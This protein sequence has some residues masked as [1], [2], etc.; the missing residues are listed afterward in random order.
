[1]RRIDASTAERTQAEIV[2]AL[3]DLNGA[4]AKKAEEYS[5][6]NDA[7]DHVVVAFDSVWANANVGPYAERLWGLDRSYAWDGANGIIYASRGGALRTDLDAVARETAELMPVLAA[8]RATGASVSG[9]VRI[10]PTPFV[11]G[12]RIIAYEEG[13]APLAPAPGRPGPD[14]PV[15]IFLNTLEAEVAKIAASR[16]VADLRVVAED[17]RRNGGAATV[18]DAA[19]LPLRDILGQPFGALAWTPEQPGRTLIDQAAPYGAG[20][21]LALLALL[22]LFL[23]L[24]GHLKRQEPL[25]LSEARLA[26]AQRVARLA[27]TVHLPDDRLEVSDNLMAMIGLPDGTGPTTTTAYLDRVVPRHRADVQEAYRLAWAED[28]RFDIEYAVTRADG[29][30]LHL[31]EVGEPFHDTNGLVLGLITAIQDITARLMAEETIRH[32]ASYDALT[33]LPNRTL[34]YDRLRQA[35]RR[36]TRAQNGMALLFVDLNRF[37]WVNDT[38]GHQ[39]GDVLLREAAQRMA[40]CI[41]ESETIARIGGDEFTVILSEVTSRAEAETVARRI[42]DSVKEPFLIAGQTLHI[43]ASIGITVAPE[44]GTEIQQL[45]KNAD[46]AMYQAKRQ[47]AGTWTFYAPEMDADAFARLRLENDLHSAVANGQLA[48]YLQPIVDVTRG[49]PIGAEAQVRWRHPEQGLLLPAAFLPLA[50]T[51]GLIVPVGAWMLDAACRQLAGWRARGLTSL[52]L[53]VPVSA[54]QLRHPGVEEMVGACLRRHEVPADGLILEIPES[55]VLDPSV[56]MVRAMRGLKALGVAFAVGGFGTGYASLGHLRRLPV[57]FLKVD[58]S[59]VQDMMHSLRNQ[60]MVRAIV[61]LARSMDLKVI[62]DGVETGEQQALAG[63]IRCEYAQGRFLGQPVPA[64]EF[65]RSLAAPLLPAN[66]PVAGA[67][68]AVPGASPAETPRPS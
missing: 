45:V 19:L 66:L 68:V 52:S 49:V 62:A 2:D 11:F 21:A 34:F 14:Q 58:R 31:Q 67:L 61:D 32:Q 48:L 20:F 50:E 9:I 4:M 64:E 18:A 39:A 24:L 37:K 5:L 17:G 41:R 63:R 29:G 6:W 7:V 13:H 55:A 33:G 40:S 28:T 25:R 38:L 22:V 44:Q 8:A 51:N 56:E 43:S 42:L 36:A 60:E 54:S 16:H 12:A 3:D 57:E 10:G 47:G 53:A 30:L 1:M 15:Q 23:H 27:Y 46:V 59:I 35:I 65:E 26:Q